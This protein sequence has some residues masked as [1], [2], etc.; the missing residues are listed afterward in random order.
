MHTVARVRPGVF[1]HPS[2]EAPRPDLIRVLVVDDNPGDARI[3]ALLLEDGPYSC[4]T[5]SSYDGGLEIIRQGVHDAYLIDY[6]LGN[7][8]GLEL[9]QEIYDAA[10]GPLILLTGLDDPAL[11]ELAQA[12]GASDYLSKT[13]LTFEDVT[14][15]IRYAVETWR[16]RRAAE[17]DRERFRALYEGV[18]IGIGRLSIH[19][20]FTEANQFLT[21]LFRYPQGESLIGKAVAELL[22]RPADVDTLLARSSEGDSPVPFELRMKHHDG[23]PLWVGGVLR[24]RRG[25]DGEVSDFEG[26]IGD[27]TARKTAE[28]Q[29]AL[30][31]AILDQVGFAVVMTDLSGEVSF[32][33]QHSEHLF[34]WR[35]D[36]VLG[37][38]I[39]EIL[40]PL[41]SADETAEIM[42]VIVETGHWAG[43]YDALRRDGSIVPLFVTNTVISDVDGAAVG[44]VG[45]STDI[46]GRKAAE[47]EIRFQA[48][49]LDQVQNAV[50]ATDLAGMVS[51]GIA[52]PSSCLVGRPT[53][54]WG[55]TKCPL[56]GQW[57][58]SMPPPSRRSIRPSLQRG[59]EPPSWPR[60]SGRGRSSSLERM[61]RVFRPGRA[62]PSCGTTKGTRL[63]SWQTAS[64]SRNRSGRRPRRNA[65]ASLHARC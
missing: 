50:I 26:A 17:V 3:I 65:R 7:R 18:P 57:I 61:A 34:G 62:T 36:E 59:S 48:S 51:T 30:Q 53:K 9:I 54:S 14:R 45:I 20:T 47:A 41:T 33:N 19:G 32:W 23:S 22:D 52:T 13:R 16:A 35:S 60:G 31:G 63:A 8:T 49:L 24:A 2:D 38:P 1:D 4:A 55:A 40:A 25:P 64:T 27:I 46:T 56:S 28:E 44:I 15:S 43:E 58:R 29:V 5:V 37:R 11:D 42:R 10:S 6:R 12:A 21:N 39:G